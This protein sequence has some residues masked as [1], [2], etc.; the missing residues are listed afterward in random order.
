MTLTE[1]KVRVKLH[2]AGAISERDDRGGL[3]V[4]VRKSTLDVADVESGAADGP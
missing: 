2:H 1:A 3:G 4:R